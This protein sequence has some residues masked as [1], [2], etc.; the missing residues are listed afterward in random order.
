MLI[1]RLYILAKPFNFHER[2]VCKK[3]MEVCI[4][5]H[6]MIAEH[7][8]DGYESKLFE[9]GMESTEKGIFIEKDCIEITFEWNTREELSNA[10]GRY[11]SDCDWALTLT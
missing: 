1:C 4:I 3:F 10:K 11:V 7:R 6:S 8:R 9:E 2:T 5:M